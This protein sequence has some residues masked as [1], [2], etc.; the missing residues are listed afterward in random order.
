[1]SQRTKEEILQ[2]VDT[3][4]VTQKFLLEALLDIRELLQELQA[5]KK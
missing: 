4:G 3:K 5:K 2:E 1:M